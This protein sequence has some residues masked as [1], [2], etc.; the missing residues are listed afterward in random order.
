M[1]TGRW[2]VQTLV[3]RVLNRLNVV[4]YNIVFRAFVLSGE[5]AFSFCPC[6]TAHA[7]P[8]LSHLICRCA[9]VRPQLV[10]LADKGAPSP[11]AACPWLPVVSM[12]PLRA[13][14][15]PCGS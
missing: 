11:L 7:L 12:H 14:P 10:I 1:L 2:A 13:H 8:S 6:C 4:V 15:Q 5:H 3:Q 9:T